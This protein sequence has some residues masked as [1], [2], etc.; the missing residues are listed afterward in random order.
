MADYGKLTAADRRAYAARTERASNDAAAAARRIA[1]R[2]YHG[3]SNEPCYDTGGSCNSARRRQP[4]AREAVRP[5]GQPTY[6][7]AIENYVNAPAYADG[8]GGEKELAAFQQVLD[9]L[10][11]SRISAILDARMDA[12]FRA[13]GT[14][15]TNRHYIGPLRFAGWWWAAALLLTAWLVWGGF[16]F[17]IL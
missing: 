14:S 12:R 3:A 8:S 4:L 2:H 6:E 17:H 13:D 15:W 11:E 10:P 16:I 5:A 1:R 9:S 7:Q